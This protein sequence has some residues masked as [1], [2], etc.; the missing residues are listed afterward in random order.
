MK[1]SS[2]KGIID[3]H[4]NQLRMVF[5][6]I[7]QK[8]LRKANIKYYFKLWKNNSLKPNY[9]KISIFQKKNKLNDTGNIIPNIYKK[10]FGRENIQLNYSNTK[11]NNSEFQNDIIYKFIDNENKNKNVNSSELSSSKNSISNK[12]IY[13]KKILKN[14]KIFITIIIINII[15]TTIF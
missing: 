14:N 8:N 11:I 9:R 5:N 4:I 10:Y 15:I 6:L 2:S 1:N 7:H 13:T 12:I 3:D